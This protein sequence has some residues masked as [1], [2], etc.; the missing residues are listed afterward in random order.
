[1]GYHRPTNQ[2]F[3]MWSD[4]VNDTDYLWTNVFPYFQKSCNFTGPDYT[5]RGPDTDVNY[6]PAAFTPGAGPLKVSFTNFYHPISRFAKAAFDK[7]GFKSIAGFNSGHLL[8]YSDWT[9]TVNPDNGVRS[10]SETSFL[11]E[12]IRTSVHIRVYQRTLA[13]HIMFN[14]NKT[15]TGV[16]VS[17]E[18]MEY[19]L[20]ARKE[21]ILA[22]GA[23]SKNPVCNFDHQFN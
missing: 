2:S 9:I 15:A 20:S 3:H 22:A 18:G 13:K 10:S 1:M 14:S 23:V 5:K 16:H 12:T 8:G 4:S 6:D 19:M 21:V 7:L 11:Q 17:T